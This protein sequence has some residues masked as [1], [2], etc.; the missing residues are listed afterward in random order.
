MP[1][2]GGYVPITHGPLSVAKLTRLGRTGKLSLSAK[3]LSGTAH[4]TLF[5]PT[6]AKLIKAAMRKKKGINNLDMSAGELAADMIYH[7]MAG[8]GMSGG[9]IWSWLKNKAYPWLKQH[10]DVIKPAIS[11]VADAAIPAITTAFG[12]TPQSGVLVRQGVKA[13]T[14]VG[15]EERRLMALEK[16]RAA[17]AAKRE[18]VSV[19]DGFE[20]DGSSFLS[21]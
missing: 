5:H 9:S 6:N 18:K 16:A 7:G 21:R 13:V 10:W 3:E 20:M 19:M 14:G 12:G 15:F 11:L 8:S 2:Y 1:D 17:K 4:K